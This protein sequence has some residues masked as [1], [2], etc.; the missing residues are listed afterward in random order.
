MPSRHAAPH[1]SLGSF[2]LMGFSTLAFRK[3]GQQDDPAPA[4][5]PIGDPHRPAV[6][7]KPQLS[8]LTVKLTSVWLTEEYPF[9]GQPIKAQPH[10]HLR[11]PAKRVEPVPNLGLHLDFPPRISRHDQAPTICVRGEARAPYPLLLGN[12]Q[13]FPRRVGRKGTGGIV[14]GYEAGH[15][16]G[17]LEPGQAGYFAGRRAVGQGAAGRAAGVRLGVVGGDLWRGRH[18]PAGLDSGPHP[19]HPPRHRGVPG[20][21]P[22][23]GHHRHAVRH[24]GGAGRTGPGHLRTG[25]VGPPNCRGVVRP[26]VG[27]AQCTAARLR[28]HHQ[29]GVRPPRAAD[30]RRIANQPAV[31]RPGRFGRRQAAQVDPAYE[32]RHSRV[33]GHRR[34]G[35]H[36]ADGR[37]GRRVA[38]A[39]LHPGQRPPLHRGHPEGARPGRAHLGRHRDPGRGPGF[40]HR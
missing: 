22:P 16:G 13:V 24:P 26:A 5:Y 4:S 17:H 14:K 31:H 36:R 27:Q 20:G 30:P 18:H 33:S 6:K 3:H 21:R 10:L 1:C 9:T 2:D 28:V 8:K 23:P 34:A 19:P 15:R 39:G 35:Q 38:A 7:R 12:H 29:E 40:H 32:P 37:V 11:A 25:A